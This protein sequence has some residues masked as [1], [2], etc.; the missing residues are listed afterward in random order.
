[1]LNQTELTGELLDSVVVNLILELRQLKQA[2]KIGDSYIGMND[3]S[4]DARLVYKA[5]ED[6]EVAAR[7]NQ[8]EIK[9]VTSESSLDEILGIGDAKFIAIKT[10]LGCW[11]ILGEI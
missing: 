2:H 5:L 8:L 1:M 7:D 11:K 3:K 4:H 6:L 9:A 10:E